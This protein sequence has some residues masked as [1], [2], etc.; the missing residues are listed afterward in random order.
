MADDKKD[1]EIHHSV[2]PDSDEG[3]QRIHRAVY[4]MEQAWPVLGPIVAIFTNWKAWAAGV[5]IYAFLARDDVRSF[6][7]SLGGK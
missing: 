2:A 3:W 7:L 5:A 1:L 4:R 6:I